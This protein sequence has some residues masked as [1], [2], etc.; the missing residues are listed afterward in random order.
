MGNNCDTGDIVISFHRLIL[1]VAE[2]HMSLTWF[3]SCT[4]EVGAAL[5]CATARE[6][7]SAAAPGS[8][9]RRRTAPAAATRTASWFPAPARRASPATSRGSCDLTTEGGCTYSRLATASSAAA[10]TR[11]LRSWVIRSRKKRDKE[12]RWRGSNRDST[13]CEESSRTARSR[14]RQS[15]C[16]HSEQ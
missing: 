4:L 14:A 2:E 8:S 1:S 11:P 10:T 9:S 5:A 6:T 12:A 3:V 13:D 16:K 7:T 15:S